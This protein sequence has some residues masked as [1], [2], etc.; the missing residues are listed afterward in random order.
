[1]S[2][3]NFTINSLLQ[4]NGFSEAAAGARA[5]GTESKGAA[6]GIEEMATAMEVVQTAVEGFLAL[7]VVQFLRDLVTGTIEAQKQE[8]QLKIRVDNTGLSYDANRDKIQAFL[9]ATQELTGVHKEELIPTFEKLI[10]VTGSVRTAQEN[11]NLAVAV[12][13]AL[14]IDSAQAAK[15][16][17]ALLDNQAGGFRMLARAVGAHGAQLK[18][19]NFVMD[20]TVKK[21]G[22]MNDAVSPLEKSTLDISNMWKDMKLELGE[23][24]GPV[25]VWIGDIFLRLMTTIIASVRGTVDLLG[26]L[27]M[28]LTE[29]LVAPLAAFS[30]KFN[31]I[32]QEMKAQHAALV[33]NAA[34]AGKKI[35]DAWD[36]SLKKTADI[37]STFVKNL[38]EKNAELTD[39]EIKLLAESAAANASSEAAKLATSLAAIEKHKAQ[40]I[41][42]IKAMEDFRLLSKKNQDALLAT[43]EA[44]AQ[45]KRMA[46]QGQYDKAEW[47]NE[48][49]L[50]DS[51]IALMQA[52]SNQKLQAQLNELNA[53]KLAQEKQARDTI[54]NEIDL[55]NTLMTI[56]NDAEAKKK[57]LVVASYQAQS[58]TANQYAEIIGT[59]TGQM[60]SGQQDAWKSALAQ[61]IKMILDKAAIHVMAAYMEGGAE[62]VAQGGWVG[63]ASGAALI[64]LGAAASAAVSALAGGGSASSTGSTVSSMMVSASPTTDAAGT[65]GANNT[66]TV[67]VNLYGDTINDPSYLQNLAAKLSAAVNNKSVRLV[68]SQVSGTLG[69]S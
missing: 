40:Q 16:V 55:Q 7:Q 38:K 59:T 18:D 58:A 13:R 12:G 48:K 9:Q 54:K 8:N 25:L 44:E 24:L 53:E 65:A 31:A 39:D 2:T 62:Q 66:S 15:M 22:S 50:M 42:A 36:F 1:M 34:D 17:G 27:A 37:H 41:T 30:S 56:D 4:G 14:S 67:N 28:G 68:A 64:A 29:M 21:F 52:G 32:Y 60:L 63:V 23:G 11:L 46:A 5:V 47:D 57:A 3:L 35:V 33:A 10:D 20:E 49:K 61:I 6:A 69:A 51:K 45:T 43:A 26:G 19:A